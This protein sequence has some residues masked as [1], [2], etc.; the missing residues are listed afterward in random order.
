[1]NDQLLTATKLSSMDSKI[2][3]LQLSFNAL[4]NLFMYYIQLFF[5]TH[6]VPDNYINEQAFAQATGQ[7]KQWFKDWSYFMYQQM[8]G[9]LEQIN[10]AIMETAAAA[11]GKSNDKEA[12]K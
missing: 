7:T 6:K 8:P 4:Q 5:Y 11:Q 9:F 1:M 2:D 3:S 12:G 10:S